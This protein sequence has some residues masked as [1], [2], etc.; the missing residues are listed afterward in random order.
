M[1]TGSQ[2]IQNANLPWDWD[3]LK[4]IAAQAFRSNPR[5]FQD[6]RTRAV[7]G[8]YEASLFEDVTAN[9]PLVDYVRQHLPGRLEDALPGHTPG[10]VQRIPLGGYS[11]ERMEDFTRRRAS[12][13]EMRATTVHRD[14]TP[15]FQQPTTETPIGDSGRRKAAQA[16]GVTMADTIG[17]QGLMNL[18]RQ[19]NALEAATSEATQQ[20]NHNAQACW[21]GA[22]TCCPTRIS[23]RSAPM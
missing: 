8:G 13:A 9:S 18:W 19:M 1:T 23:R 2:V 5:A 21:D 15:E 17:V 4:W 12:D 6:A 11:R 10:W 7:G 16:L 3:E 20:G 22:A 14:F